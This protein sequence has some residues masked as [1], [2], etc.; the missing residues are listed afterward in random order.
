MTGNF[1]RPQSEQSPLPSHPARNESFWQKLKAHRK[2]II[3]SF[4]V[5][6]SLGY[7]IYLISGL[8]SLQKLENI[9]PALVTRIYSEDGEIIHELYRYNRVYIPI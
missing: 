5:A 3:I 7:L 4:L 2:I 8:P 6:L 1:N 9:E